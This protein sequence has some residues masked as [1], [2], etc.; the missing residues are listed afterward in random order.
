MDNG[1]AIGSGRRQPPSGMTCRMAAFGA[2]Q[3]L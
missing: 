2:G 3:A 1:V